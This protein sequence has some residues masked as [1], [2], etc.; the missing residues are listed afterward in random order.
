M[1]DALSKTVT[2]AVQCVR[3]KCLERAQRGV[4]E[5]S[6]RQHNPHSQ[7][8]CSEN[9]KALADTLAERIKSELEPD[10]LDGLEVSVTKEVIMVDCKW[11]CGFLPGKPAIV[12]QLARTSAVAR[13][14]AHDKLSV[15]V[16]TMF[17]ERCVNQAKAL[18]ERASVRV[19]MSDLDAWGA[20]TVWRTL[21]Q[22]RHVAGTP[23]LRARIER[24]ISELGL[25]NPRCAYYTHFPRGRIYT[26]HNPTAARRY[27][28][29]AIALSGSPGA[30][31]ARGRG[32]A[33]RLCAIRDSD[34][35]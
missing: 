3:D 20:G 28:G 24:R 4:F 6:V 21:V 9:E 1:D 29:Y 5:A 16:V 7:A 17:K 23:Y 22:C 13:Y 25:R 10:G 11:K 32:T 18:I 35:R 2:S 14:D 15:K 26:Y 12:A 27:T 30:A 19:C 33:V 31:R 8:W 34:A